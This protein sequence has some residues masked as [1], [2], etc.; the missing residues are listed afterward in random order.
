MQSPQRGA[1]WDSESWTTSRVSLLC[2][3]LTSMSLAQA[4]RTRVGSQVGEGCLG[5]LIHSGPRQVHL[6]LKW[7][8]STD[9]ALSTMWH[10]TTDTLEQINNNICFS[11]SMCF[12][13]CIHYITRNKKC[14]QLSRFF[15]CVCAPR[16]LTSLCLCC[17]WWIE[18]IILESSWPF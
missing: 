10:G 16:M 2:K 14:I 3:N 7:P 6:A 13:C 4:G 5:P 18:A 15:C 1:A 12:T 9:A 8:G 17:P 11:K